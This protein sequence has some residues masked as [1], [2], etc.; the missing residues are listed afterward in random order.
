MPKA[1]ICENTL[2]LQKNLALSLKAINIDSITPISLE[3]AL[4]ALETE[5]ISIVIIN[6]N[7][8]NQTLSKNRI[9]QWI[10]NLPMYRRRD[11]MLI[12]T[13]E[14][15]KTLDRL[16]AFAK[17]ADL[18]I[19]TKDLSNFYSIFKIGYLEYQLTYKQ[20]KQLL[21]K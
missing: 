15:L 13:G 20:Y 1:L 21:S 14:N 6:E 8:A 4:R 7:F 10:T 19:N 18:I 3:D 9:I 11:I 12:I 2:E 16:T 5:D 17:N